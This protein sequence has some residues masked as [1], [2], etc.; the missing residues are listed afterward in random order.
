VIITHA[1]RQAYAIEV[2]MHELFDAREIDGP[3]WPQKDDEI[4]AQAHLELGIPIMDSTAMAPVIPL[5]HKVEQALLLGDLSTLST[6]EKLT[7]YHQTCASLGLNPLT[8]PFEYLTF[9]GKL[10]MYAGKNCA[11]QL[12]MIHAVSLCVTARERLEDLYIVTV[13]ATMPDGRQDEDDGAVPISNLKGEALS[14]AMMKA[15]TKAKNRATLSIC[16]LAMMDASEVDSIPGAVGY[17]ETPAD[18]RPA[19]ENTRASHQP[20]SAGVAVATPEGILGAPHEAKASAS[21]ASAA[22]TVDSVG[23]QT[24]TPP[25]RTT[26]ELKAAINQ[27]FKRL[28]DRYSVTVLCQKAWGTRIDSLEKVRQLQDGSLRNGLKRLQ[29]IRTE[30]PQADPPPADAGV[31]SS[32]VASSP[33]VGED[34]PDFPPPDGNPQEGPQQPPGETIAGGGSTQ[35]GGGVLDEPPDEPEVMAMG[36]SKGFVY[37]SSVRAL[38]DYA[39]AVGQLDTFTD[40]THHVALTNGVMAMI[41]RQ[42]KMILQAVKWAVANPDEVSS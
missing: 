26:E 4:R 22:S 42:Y 32:H 6:E 41:P 23:G 1:Q 18:T 12:R 20:A 33:V 2:R 11:Q 31:T 15:T 19:I 24:T 16:G 40:M 3:Y 29:A 9:Q 28:G 25:K 30:Q 36:P 17:E 21:P 38:R 14:N 35:G 27:E 34:V 8:K 39:E 10:R 5:S 7:L 37:P 13:R